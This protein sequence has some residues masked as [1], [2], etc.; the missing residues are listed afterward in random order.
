MKLK[1]LLSVL[2]IM[3]MVLSVCCVAQA[4]TGYDYLVG[5]ID[6]TDAVGN[7]NTLGFAGSGQATI[8]AQVVDG[9]M[10]LNIKRGYYTYDSWVNGPSYN[11]TGK[12]GVVVEFKIRDTLNMELVVGLNSNQP[13]MK[14]ETNGDVKA[15]NSDKILCKVN[16]NEWY[17]YTATIDYSSKTILFTIKDSLGNVLCNTHHVQSPDTVADQMVAKAGSLIRFKM[18]EM[19]GAGDYNLGYLDDFSVRA[20]EAEDVESFP[21]APVSITGTIV[22]E[23]YNDLNPDPVTFNS[24]AGGWSSVMYNKA[25]WENCLNGK[26]YIAGGY[27]GT[28][29]I[30]ET[31][32]GSGDKYLEFNLNTSGDKTLEYMYYNSLNKN[33]YIQEVT[34][35]VEENVQAMDFRYRPGTH[36]IP[37]ARLDFQNDKVYLGNASSTINAEFDFVPGTQYTAKAYYAWD[38]HKAKIEITDGTKSV[39]L[40]GGLNCNVNTATATEAPFIRF[41]SDNSF[42]EGRIISIYNYNIYTTDEKSCELKIRYSNLKLSKNAFEEGS[43]TAS[44]DAESNASFTNTNYINNAATLFLA[45]YEDG[46]LSEL[47]SLQLSPENKSFSVTNTIGAN[48]T[49]VKAM[50]W[51]VEDG[52]YTPLFVSKELAKQQ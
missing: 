22:A 7:T 20:L 37:V 52:T 4:D 44:V 10:A 38:A 48:D 40:Y 8:Y 42:D 50:L 23:D 17:T 33:N 41:D 26:G 2:I 15:T 49:S 11:S 25:G 21:L 51:N 28:A 27:L 34:F 13:L 5:P 14:I 9:D 6:F 32:E 18:N 36:E 31:S 1:K 29:S 39:V 43:I 19:P 24:G 3:T 46:K 47:K 45:V 16:A 30:K 35:K 12:D